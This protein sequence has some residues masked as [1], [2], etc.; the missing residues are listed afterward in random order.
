M[1]PKTYQV[2]KLNTTS[3]KVHI[4]GSAYKGEYPG[5]TLRKS[6]NDNKLLM[7]TR[8][9]KISIFELKNSGKLARAGKILLGRD[10]SI[11]DF[12]SVSDNKVIIA[13]STTI[14]LYLFDK[15]NFEILSFIEMKKKLGENEHISSLIY[16]KKY[17]KLFVAFFDK[18]YIYGTRLCIFSLDQEKRLCLNTIVNLGVDTRSGVIMKMNIDEYNEIEEK[19]EDLTEKRKK[20]S[21]G[22]KGKKISPTFLYCFEATGDCRMRVYKF[23]SSGLKEI[24]ENNDLSCGPC[25]ASEIFQRAMVSIGVNGEMRILDL[26]QVTG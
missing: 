7:L 13:T 12:T 9:F 25:Y 24:G 18:K 14:F 3:D 4:I 5:R 22:T 15:K 2:L 21:K 1:N 6:F 19:I 20:K 23:G 8:R 11:I 16:S 26:S 17:K 10:S